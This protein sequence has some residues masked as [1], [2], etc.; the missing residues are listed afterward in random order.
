MTDPAARLFY[1][2]A[3]DDDPVPRVAS[4]ATLFPDGLE[5]GTTSEDVATLKPGE[6]YHAG[7]W[8]AVRC[9]LAILDTAREL[10]G[11]GDDATLAATYLSSPDAGAERAAMAAA[12]RQLVAPAGVECQGHPAGPF[13]AMGSTVYCD[14]SCANRRPAA[15]PPRPDAAVV[16]AVWDL[17]AARAPGDVTIEAL[18]DAGAVAAVLAWDGR[19]WIGTLERDGRIARVRI[20]AG[21][22]AATATLDDLGMRVDPAALSALDSLAI[23]LELEHGPARWP[24]SVDRTPPPAPLPRA[25]AISRGFRAQLEAAGVDVATARSVAMPSG[26]FAIG[27]DRGGPEACECGA[28]FAPHPGAPGEHTRTC[29]CDEL[30]PDAPADGGGQWERRQLGIGS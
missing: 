24:L 18:D 30:E 17:V 7:V 6:C 12:I 14:G 21:D 15:A 2:L 20:K 11:G 9:D 29:D 10:D 28:P 27:D 4:F 8:A 3:T 22:R 26:D 5:L 25:I 16:A 23:S 1:L 19:Q 13:D